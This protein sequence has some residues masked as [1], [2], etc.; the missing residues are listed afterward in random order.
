MKKTLFAIWV[1]AI[2]C[3]APTEKT[4]SADE[5]EKQLK[6]EKTVLLLDVRTGE[7]FSERH[8]EN[9]VNIDFRSDS[10]EATIANLD[11]TQPIYL[12]CLSGGR[13][14]EA[15]NLLHEKGFETVYDLQGGILAWANAGK[16]LVE[17]QTPK[18][19][20]LDKY[21]ELVN[22]DK[23]VLVDFNA[24]WCA[25]CK[26]LKPIIHKV[27]EENEQ[28]V[29]LLEIDVDENSV[30]SDKMHIDRIPLLILYKRGKEV[31]RN[32]GVIE[33]K[34]L[35]KTIGSFGSGEKEV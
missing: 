5:F 16:P 2:G 22:K 10:F 27:I 24:V 6:K 4:L 25:P 23:M 20:S 26:V 28:N 12:Y 13:S 19:I 3:N 15:A 35:R 18:G 9:A 1:L 31:W 17:T 30:L 32:F 11:K 21:L 8:L 7:E 33:E 34:E 29:E 14:G